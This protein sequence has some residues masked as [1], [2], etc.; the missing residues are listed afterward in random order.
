MKKKGETVRGNCPNTRNLCGE[1]K[2]GALVL[3]SKKKKK[4]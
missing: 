4:G 1:E 3:I 2:E